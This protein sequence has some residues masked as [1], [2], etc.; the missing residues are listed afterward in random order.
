MSL[1]S[2]LEE[3]QTTKD[4]PIQHWLFVHE[5]IAL[6]EQFSDDDWVEINAVGNLNVG[7]GDH[8]QYATIRLQ[9]GSIDWWEE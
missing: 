1:P 6:L 4:H 7:R 8:P 5:L 2:S 3:K 9:T